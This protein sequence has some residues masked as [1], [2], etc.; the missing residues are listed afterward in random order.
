MID[1]V[2][3]LNLVYGSAA[4][5]AVVF[6]AFLAYRSR[7]VTA[8]QQAYTRREKREAKAQEQKDAPIV[9]QY[10]YLTVAVTAI[11]QMLTRYYF[12]KSGISTIVTA[13]ILYASYKGS[14]PGRLLHGIWTCIV[15]FFGSISVVTLV[16]LLLRSG[17]QAHAFGG[18]QML[19]VNG[20]FVLVAALQSMTFFRMVGRKK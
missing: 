6:V 20:G 14:F 18:V 11:M 7:R 12:Q 4:L 19:L 2:L 8:G 15:V 17:E 3:A 16:G 9:K 10:I 13:V 1:I 5:F